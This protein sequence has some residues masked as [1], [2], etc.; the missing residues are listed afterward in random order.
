MRIQ[1]EWM[2]ASILFLGSDHTVLAQNSAE[3]SALA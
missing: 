2:L 1:F 3:N